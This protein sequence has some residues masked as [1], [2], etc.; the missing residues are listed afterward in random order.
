MV[1]F[2]GREH[3]VLTAFTWLNATATIHLILKM[4][5]A[6]VQGR[7]LIEGGVYSIKQ[8]LCAAT[9]QYIKIKAIVQRKIIYTDLLSLA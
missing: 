8:L 4:Y 6:T 5:V 7:P 2:N 1:C 9:V 3:N